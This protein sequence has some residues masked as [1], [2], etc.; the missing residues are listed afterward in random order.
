VLL[1]I[2]AAVPPSGSHLNSSAGRESS[3]RT[4][5]TNAHILDT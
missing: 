5:K 1:D 3:L 2:A 4:G